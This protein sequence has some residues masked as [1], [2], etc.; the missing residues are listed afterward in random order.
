MDFVVLTFLCFV[1]VY[2][3]WRMTLHNMNV[4]YNGLGAVSSVLAGVAEQP[5]QYRVLVPWLTGDGE[6]FQVRYI[7]LKHLGIVTAIVLSFLYLREVS[8]NPLLAT[9][10]FCMY[11]VYAA[12]Y[13]YAD[14][15]FEILFFAAAWLL[16]LSG[17]WW[18]FLLIPLT[19]V[20]GLNRETAAFIPF[21]TLLSGHFTLAAVCGLAF[22]FAWA[23]PREKYGWQAKRYC[24]FNRIGEN[25]ELILRWGGPI[26]WV[27]EYINFATLLAL[28]LSAYVY[29][30][31]PLSGVEWSMLIFLFA[32]ITPTLWREI[33][34]FAP[35]VLVAIGMVM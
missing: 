12:I 8:G 31:F 22:V 9:S 2:A 23:L 27:N 10:L 20:A 21:A 6:N 29:H 11:L 4:R 15:Y 28:V 14:G 3:D 35:V 19:F 33:R 16:L 34:V 30:W 32:M 13:D 7:I 1:V 25:V 5:M 18:V 17:G 26:P 24:K